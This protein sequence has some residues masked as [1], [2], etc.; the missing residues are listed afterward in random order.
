MTASP[1]A[2]GD[3]STAAS[4]ADLSPTALARESL[5]ATK[6][7]DD[8]EPYERALAGLDGDALEAVRADRP[9]ALAFWTNLYNA[10][11]QLLLDRRP[12]LY[13][14]PLRS[15]RFFTATA[16][17]V[18]G[19]DLPLDRIENGLL[20]ARRSKYGLGYLPKL[21]VTSFERRYALDSCDPRVHFALNCGAASCPAIRA[22]DP[23]QLDEQLDLATR[24]YLDSAVEYDADDGVARVPRVFL[25]FRGDFGGKSGTREFLREYD[26]VPATASPAIAYRPWDWSRTAGKFAD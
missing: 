24:T 7:G 26:A 1:S 16:V 14:S 11:T 6:R 25:W 21:Y 18:A 4:V 19:A 17:T 5:V 10:G 12:D 20:R 8:P 9:T 13:E 2:A 22:Y 23:E 15:I 3:A